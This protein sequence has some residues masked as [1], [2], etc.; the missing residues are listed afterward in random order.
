LVSH[1]LAHQWFGDLATCKDWSQIWL[2]EGFATYYS[3]LYA[4]HKQGRDEFLYEMYGNANRVLDQANDTNAIV[5]RDY[6]DPGDQFGYLAYP[7]GAWVL[8]MLRHQLGPDLYRAC[9]RTYLERHQFGNVVTEDLRRVIEELSGRSFDQFFDQWLY[10]AHHPE[11][12]INYSYDAKAKMAKLSVSQQQKLS[13]QV[14]LFRVPLTFRFLSSSGVTDRTVTVEKASEDFYFPLSEPPDSVRVDPEF[15]LLAK[16]DFRPQRN[17]L[18]A[19]LTNETDVIG[20]LL[21]V[22]AMDRKKDQETIDLLKERLNHDPFHGVRQAASKALRA[23]HTDEAFAALRESTDQPDARVRQQ[24]T[25]DLGDFYRVE[26]RLA[27]V[28]Q[29]D[30]EHNPDILSTALRALGAYASPEISPVLLKYLR[31]QSYRNRLADAAIDAL[32]NQQDPAAIAPLQ[33][34]LQ[35]KEPAFTS[36]GFA[37]GLS[38]LGYLARNEDHKEPVRGFLA[39]Y[40]NHPRRTIRLAAI[41]A[42]GTLKDPAAIPQLET[43]T[44]AIKASAERQAAEGVLRRLRDENPPATQLGNLRGEVLDLQKSNR[45]LSSQLEDLKKKFEA[46]SKATP[47]AR[48]AQNDAKPADDRK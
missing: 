18:H 16:V 5:R 14:L 38:A 48:P 4:E 43:F 35:E 15:T 37:S 7:K 24:V 32:R 34:V 11:L 47:S 29:L 40:L 1:E 42:L 27:L 31:S 44:T 9:I 25:R 33:A 28:R 6:Q 36:N 2:N 26:T 22:E 13:R 45:E 12:Q 41:R 30:N 10:H 21:A 20:R 39:R 17:M 46:F 23:I 3:A 19:Q 8:H